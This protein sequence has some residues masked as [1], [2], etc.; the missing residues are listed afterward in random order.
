MSEWF[1]SYGLAEVYDGLVIGAF[2]LDIHDVDTLAGLRVR[3][4]LN[5]VSEDE[6]SPGQHDHVLAAYAASGIFEERLNLVDFGHLPAE[7]L[8]SAVRLVTGWL[9]AGM[10][11]YVHCRAGWQRSAAVAAGVVAVREGLDIDDALFFVRHRKPSA[12]P[13]PH[14]IDDLVRWWESR[15]GH[16]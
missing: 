15:N 11:S 2:P 4:V 10:S 9:D 5:L 3:R 14:Q 12:D 6:Y 16:G 7:V 13:L 1:D 8:E